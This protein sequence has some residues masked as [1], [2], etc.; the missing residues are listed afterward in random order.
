[1][2]IRRTELTTLLNTGTALSV[3]PEGDG[4]KTACCDARPPVPSEST[5]P[6]R[7]TEAHRELAAA[8]PRLWS[9][10][11]QGNT[12]R[13]TQRK[14]LRELIAWLVQKKGWQARELGSMVYS[15]GTERIEGRVDVLVF[16]IEHRPLLAIEADWTYQADSLAKLSAAH[17]QGFAV[18]W[19]VGV[20][21]ESR[22][23]AREARRFAI[24]QLGVS[25]GAWLLIYHLEHGWL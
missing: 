4:T 25:A 6:A 16:D 21:A 9:R 19:V 24:R 5:T 8:L 22:D 10:A 11:K 3:D 23:Q 18:L 14:K 17:T 1:M 12:P 13:S 20:A 7:Y 2:K 15:N